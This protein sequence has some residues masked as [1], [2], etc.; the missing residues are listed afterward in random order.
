MILLKGMERISMLLNRVGAVIAIVLI[1]YMLGHILLEIALR[2]F[3]HSTYILDEY[4]GYAVA[5]MSFLGL[6]YVLEK[7]GLIRVSLL[8]ERIPMN[9]RWPLEFFSSL[10]TASCFLWISTFWFQN[11]QRSFSRGVV[12][13]T[14]AE[15]PIWI[16]EGAILIGMW[17][18]SFSLLVRALKILML[19]SQYL[20]VA[21]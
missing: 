17:L 4:I 20:P 10:L 15:T 12:S 19:R 5:T 11:V 21:E 6:P 7:G 2:F 14:L 9:R 16:P 3:G 8:L 18:I 1:V 13:E